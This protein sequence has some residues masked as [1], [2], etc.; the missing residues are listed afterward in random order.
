MTEY[1]KSKRRYTPPRT[2]VHEIMEEGNLLAGTT[3]TG[4][5]IDNGETGGGSN[6]PKLSKGIFAIENDEIEE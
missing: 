1:T 2:N 3:V 5:N 4:G 6:N